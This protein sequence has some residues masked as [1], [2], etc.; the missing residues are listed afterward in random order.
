MILIL[1]ISPSAIA[2]KNLLILAITVI[3]I[4][5]VTIV[6]VM[7][8]TPCVCLSVLFLSVSLSP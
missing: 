3:V 6:E 8:I 1:T 4:S 2:A 7:K 5:V